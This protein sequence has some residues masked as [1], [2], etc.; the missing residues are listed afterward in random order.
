M[1]KIREFFGVKKSNKIDR[2]IVNIMEVPVVRG[3]GGGGGSGAERAKLADTI[4]CDFFVCFV[5][6]F[7][8]CNCMSVSQCFYIL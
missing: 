1:Q 8:C 6:V 7:K 5:F 2:Q 4:Q 3:S